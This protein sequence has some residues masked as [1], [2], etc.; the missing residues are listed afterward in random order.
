MFWVIPAG[1]LASGLA[2]FK[3]G[4]LSRIQMA[5]GLDSAEETSS[6]HDLLRKLQTKGGE[7]LYTVI[8]GTINSDHPIICDFAK[9]NDGKGMKVVLW[10]KNMYRVF[11]EWSRVSQRWETNGQKLLSEL[12]ETT[13]YI[14]DQTGSISVL[15]DASL[16]LP[17]LKVFEKFDRAPPQ[18]FTQNVLEKLILETRELG[19]R[20]EELALPVGTHVFAIGEAIL[21][22]ATGKLILRCPSDQRP[23][24]IDQSSLAE[25]IKRIQ[26]SARV[27]WW[28]S[29]VLLALGVSVIAYKG[30]TWWKRSLPDPDYSGERKCCICL[31]KESTVVFLPCGHVCTCTDCS[32]VIQACPICRA[33]IQSRREIVFS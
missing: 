19:T 11:E 3:F 14:M 9:T 32:P 15:K 16:S 23:F 24:L 31:A 22:K 18:S 10:V 27:Y 20:T 25:I 4:Y 6:I 7:S 17:V 13:F 30:F 28:V 21:D 2:V 5:L 1:L 8:S 26:K 33:R 12:R 29:I